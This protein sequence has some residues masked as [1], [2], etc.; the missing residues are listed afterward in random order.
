MYANMFG[1]WCLV[2]GQNAL[3]P[4][5]MSGCIAGRCSGRARTRAAGCGRRG[6]ARISP[7]MAFEVSDCAPKPMATPLTPPT[8]SSGWMLSPKA[9]SLPPR[10]RRRASLPPGRCQSRLTRR[11]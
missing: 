4:R 8:A 9:C 10:A 6:R 2:F 5:R 3:L 1:V 11:C 7:E